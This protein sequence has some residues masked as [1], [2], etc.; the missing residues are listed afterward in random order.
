MPGLPSPATMP[1][2]PPPITPAPWPVA[3]APSFA[4]WTP[5]PRPGRRPLGVGRKPIEERPDLPPR[6]KADDADPVGRP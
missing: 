6:P 5:P 3:P 1:A 2:P 4:E